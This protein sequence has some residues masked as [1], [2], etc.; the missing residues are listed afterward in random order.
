MKKKILLFIVLC[1]AFSLFSCVERFPDDDVIE[2]ELNEK[3]FYYFF[4]I[5]YKVNVANRPCVVVKPLLE[6]VEYIKTSVTFSWEYNDEWGFVIEKEKQVFLFGWE[7]QFELA[8]Y[9][10]REI[11]N[12][13]LSEC[14]GVVKLKKVQYENRIKEFSNLEEFLTFFESLKSYD[15]NTPYIYSYSKEGDVKYTDKSDG[16]YK[17]NYRFANSSNAYIKDNYFRYVSEE[18]I[19]QIGDAFDDVEN[20]AV[21]SDVLV[22]ENLGLVAFAK[23]NYEKIDSKEKVYIKAY[24]TFDDAMDELVEYNYFNNFE[25]FYNFFKREKMKLS[26]IQVQKENCPEGVKYSLD[27]DLLDIDRL[28]EM[29]EHA[30][31]RLFNSGNFDRKVHIEICAHEKEVSFLF[32]LKIKKDIKGTDG[33]YYNDDVIE[34]SLDIEAKG[35]Y[36]FENFSTE[37]FV[38]YLVR[39]NKY[40]IA[41]PETMDTTYISR[42]VGEEINDLFE[43]RMSAVYYLYYLEPGQYLLESLNENKVEINVFDSKHQKAGSVLGHYLTYDEKYNSSFCVYESGWYYIET[44]V[45]SADKAKRNFV[46]TKIDDDTFFDNKKAIELKESNEFVFD[47]NYDTICF[48]YESDNEGFINFES[49][50]IFKIYYYNDKSSGITLMYPNTGNNELPIS[51]GVNYYCMVQKDSRKD[52]FYVELKASIKCIFYKNEFEITD[53]IDKMPVLTDEYSE[54]PIILPVN[55]ELKFRL[56]SSGGFYKFVY[57]IVDK[58][59]SLLDIKIYKENG[60]LF[61]QYLYNYDYELYLSEGVYII[62]VQSSGDLLYLKYIFNNEQLVYFE[63]YVFNGEELLVERGY[64]PA[65]ENEYFGYFV[66]FKEDVVFKTGSKMGDVK[67]LV[68]E[69][70]D[71]F[72]AKRVGAFA[73][74]AGKYKFVYQK[75]ESIYIPKANIHLIALGE[76]DL[77][78]FEPYNPIVVNCDG[79]KATATGIEIQEWGAG[80]NIIFGKEMNSFCFVLEVSETSKM[81]FLD[82]VQVYN[83]ECKEMSQKASVYTLTP[84]KYYVVFNQNFTMSGIGVRVEK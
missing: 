65:Y 47:T 49:Q 72:H 69:N 20:K 83:M 82:Y 3:S 14:S 4:D 73:L 9:E 32:E 10:Y 84:G 6:D 16:D 41:Y 53:D 64:N 66:E 22:E 2:V 80:L 46:L 81:K 57:E 62:S 7:R 21:K 26:N 31:G 30:K 40:F 70:G 37:Q 19:E 42:K 78:C 51:K 67:F 17:V 79:K 61:A 75:D 68:D 24:E 28:S 56:N 1:L 36:K 27:C 45:V 39:D 8:D 52:I 12:F 29:L 71:I 50:G 11:N 63:E 77:S 54:K 5:D 48:S 25:N 35:T 55:C 58:P 18:N 23:N 44:R 60:S 33:F 74:P 13:V 34:V 15:N 43:E 59:N 38:N 76:K